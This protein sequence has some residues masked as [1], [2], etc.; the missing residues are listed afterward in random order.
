MPQDAVGRA[1]GRPDRAADDGPQGTGNHFA[2]A[3]PVP[4]P[5]FEPLG[6]DSPRPC[7]RGDQPRPV[8]CSNSSCNPKYRRSR[9]RHRGA[10]PTVQ[11]PP[12]M[13]RN[14][15]AARS[16][17]SRPYPAGPSPRWTGARRRSRGFADRRGPR[18]P[19]PPK[20]PGRDRGG[21]AGR[22]A[23]QPIADADL[24][25]R[26]RLP[27]GEALA[28]QG[29]HVP[30]SELAVVERIVALHGREVQ[31]PD[32]L[33]LQFGPV[34]LDRGVDGSEAHAVAPTSRRDA[35]AWSS[36]DSIR[37][38]RGRFGPMSRKASRREVHVDVRRGEDHVAD[39]GA[40]PGREWPSASGSR[41]SA[42]CPSSGPAP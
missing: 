23:H 7:R 3:R 30:G 17:W 40:T 25:V 12:V 38:S 19:P 35:R 29:D 26:D 41:A 10:V 11:R 39:L 5:A 32:V 15:C 22:R 31:D 36:P 4:S 18:G 2:P 13:A 28:Q 42:S 1:H 6:F 20:P 24:T 9:P 14:R 21:G 34:R 37:V 16:T 8:R 27:V 33:A